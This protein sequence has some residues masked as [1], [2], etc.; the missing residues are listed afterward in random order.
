M[1]FRVDEIHP[2]VWQ[3][4][5]EDAVRKWLWQ[6]IKRAAVFCDVEDAKAI[7]KVPTNNHASICFT[8]LSDL[9]A[10]VVAD[11]F[12]FHWLQR[13][14]LIPF[15]FSALSSVDE[16]IVQ[17]L[18]S[19][20]NGG[21]HSTGLNEQDTSLGLPSAAWLIDRATRDRIQ[22]N[23]GLSGYTTEDMPAVCC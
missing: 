4:S 2:L 13:L 21:V 20:V 1:A 5:D 16:R 3:T 15:H 23:S 7:G 9:A 6:F 10:V 19:N 18:G 11:E 8:P 14:Q 22:P 12:Q 17:Q